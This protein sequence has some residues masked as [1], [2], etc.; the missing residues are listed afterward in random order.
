LSQPSGDLPN[1]FNNLN[2]ISGLIPALPFNNAEKVF[3][4]KPSALAASV[5][6]TLSGSGLV[7][8]DVMA[9]VHQPKNRLYSS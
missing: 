2:T 9:A 5:T 1:T 8:C 7:N 6:L 3:L 4:V